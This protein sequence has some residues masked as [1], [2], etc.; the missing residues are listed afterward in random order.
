MVGKKPILAI[1]QIEVEI[2]KLFISNSTQSTIGLELELIPFKK[3]PGKCDEPAEI[4]DS[5]GTGTYQFLKQSAS[6]S[7]ELFDTP[8]DDGTPQLSTIDGGNI[9]FEPGGQIEYSSSQ[10]TMLGD[11]VKEVVKYIG[12]IDDSVNPQNIWLFFGGIN[13]WFSVF[14]VGLK[15]QKQR[16]MSMDKYLGTYGRQMMRL[17]SSLQVNLDL[18]NSEEAKERWMAANLLSPLIC[19]IFANSPF[20]EGNDTGYKSYRSTIWQHL[21]KTRTGF[22]HLNSNVNH[23]SSFIQQYLEFALNA[24]VIRLPD[25]SGQLSF[26]NNHTSF[27]DWMTS[28]FNGFY[29]DKASWKSHISTLFPEVRPKGFLEFRAIDGQCRAWWTVP[30]ILLTSILYNRSATR[31]VIDLLSHDYVK[32]DKM[33]KEASKNGINAFPEKA[34][35]VFKIGL[36]TKE[37]AI[38]SE[39]LSH[40]EQF[41]KTYTE[42]GLT[43]ADDLLRLNDGQIFSISQYVNYETQL[44]EIANAPDYS[45]CPI[46]SAIMQL[47][48]DDSKTRSTDTKNNGFSTCC[49]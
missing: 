18:G 48:F 6:T 2:Q 28:G 43:P 17:T 36:N 31:K 4:V 12:L 46:H 21:D 29:P 20:V 45:I 11:A 40:C 27:K 7:K 9:T 30:A 47:P 10:S 1:E 5:D 15:N 33:L 26:I 25:P 8:K 22:P 39:L 19:A 24:H 42:K 44:L 37:F 49:C 3:Q 13:P 32:L 35:Q 14:Q 34:K 23:Q 16:Y 41:F 38:E